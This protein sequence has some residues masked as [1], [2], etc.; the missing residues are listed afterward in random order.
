MH[1][2][3]RLSDLGGTMNRL[4]HLFIGSLAV[5]AA[6]SC[7]PPEGRE[8]QE[9]TKDEAHAA[10]SAAA[11]PI[12]AAAAPDAC[13]VI[14]VAEIERLVG[15][16]EGRPKREGE[17]CWYYFPTDA[18]KPKSA[19]LGGLTFDPDRPMPFEDPR[20]GL[21]V[22]VDLDATPL[23]S[24]VAHGSGSWDA[25]GTPGARSRFTGRIGHV[26]V[27]I[28]QQRLAL[29]VDTLAA[30]AARVRDRIP[31]RPHAYPTA[32]AAAPVST[33]P[34]PCS[35]L[36]DAE[37]EAVLGELAV[38][39]FRTHEGSPLADPAGP[40]CGYFT[41][42]HRV[43]VLTPEWTYGQLT[44]N[45]ERMGSNIVSQVADI[46]DIVADTLEGPWDDAVVGLSGDLI[47]T[48][49]SRSLSIGY[50][51]SSTD[52]AGA[53]RLAGP[54]LDRLA[55]EPEPSRP[56]VSDAGCL[57]ENLVGEIVEMPVRL[58]ANVMRS[59]G[60]CAYQL[61]VDPTVSIEL[62]VQSARN[63]DQVFGAIQSGA[64]I[65]MGA[66][67][68]ADRIE[69]GEGGWAFGSG[70]KSEAAAQADGKLYHARMTYP[71]STTIPNRK[72]AMVRLVARMME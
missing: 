60:R 17:G 42:G 44:L 39:P 33:G 71:L 36:T 52:A 38:P 55:A 12:A 24:G 3:A 4:N 70:S 6:W 46:A 28:V 21:F 7:G 58:V 11:S 50:R 29:P 16:I 49:D 34:D 37:A 30:L 59:G 54:A 15:P 20:R 66:S 47:I 45:A 14:S 63:A 23:G 68:Q 35:V 65:M 32:K 57:S 27:S 13:D 41:A 72:D 69:V 26:T 40:S 56:K 5:C 18:P 62:S 43:L 64:K 48:R 67:A 31:D 8:S 51:M 25:V 22:E 2:A 19:E 10:A 1:R 53:I 61:Q 9:A